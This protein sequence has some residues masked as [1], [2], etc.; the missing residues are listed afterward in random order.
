MRLMGHKPISI[1]EFDE[2]LTT[3][4]PM[5]RGEEADVHWRGRVAPAKHLMPDTGFVAFDPPMSLYVSAFGPRALA[6]AARH[7][8]GLVMSVPP[9]PEAVTAI[10]TRLEAAATAADRALDPG[11]FLTATLTT[12]VVLDEGEAPFS[13]RVREQAG[14]FAIS[15]LH[16]TYEQWRQYGRRPSPMVADIWDEYVAML[17]AVPE[18]RRHQRIHAGHNCWVMPEEERFVTPEL[19]EATCMIGTPIQLAD[20]LRALEAAGLS[21]VMLLPPLAVKE[22]VLRDVATKVMPLLAR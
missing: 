11:S 21:Q 19:V 7:G 22:Q 2:Y 13:D 15:A 1:A 18:E 5:L 9:R 20:R 12:M 3:L 6:L 10:W 17:D 16:Y 4:R 14:A 8:D